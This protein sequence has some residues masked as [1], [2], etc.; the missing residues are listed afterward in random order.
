M[1]CYALIRAKKAKGYKY[2]NA[3]TQEED[4]L[5][6]EKWHLGTASYDE[7]IVERAARYICDGVGPAWSSAA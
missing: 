2:P 1:A 6:A 7:K 3:V 4:F 5:S